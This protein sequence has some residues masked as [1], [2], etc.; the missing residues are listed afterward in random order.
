MEGNIIIWLKVKCFDY[1]YDYSYCVGYIVNISILMNINKILLKSCEKYKN[2][3]I[4]LTI[5]NNLENLQMYI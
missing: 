4:E 2:K 1:K 3:G 5:I